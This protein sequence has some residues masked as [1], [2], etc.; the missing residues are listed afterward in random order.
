MTEKYLIIVLRAIGDVL[1][2]TPLVRAIKKNRPDSEVYF[3]TGRASEK[4][5]RHN[6]YISEVIV[7]GEGTAG[8]LRALKPDVTMDFMNSAV[9]GFYTLA[10]CAPRRMAF[11]RPWGFWCYNEMIRHKGSNVYTA[12]DRLSM[13]EPLGF[14]DFGVSLDMEFSAE[15]AEKVQRFFDSSGISGNDFIVTMDVTNRR[16]HRQWQKEKFAYVADKL[17]ETHGAR[18]IF[19]WGPGELDYVKATMGLCKKRHIL[20]P[21]FDILDLAALERSCGLH[22]GTSSAPGHIAVS[23][24]APTFIVFGEKTGPVNWTPPDSSRNRYVQGN[25]DS[26]SAEYV[27]DKLS[28]FTGSLTNKPLL[29][30]AA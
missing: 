6:R 14:R 19:L 18:V 16:L 8:R 29:P 2:T 24:G 27:F 9:S 17:A 5:L 13:L 7:A 23:Q 21:D 30:K 10:S 12:Y 11:F 28:E 1:L 22:T 25:F 4:I 15:N 20:C 3:L 26:L